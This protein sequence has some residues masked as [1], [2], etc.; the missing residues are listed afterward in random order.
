MKYLHYT[1][2]DAVTGISIE[3]EPAK[4]GPASPAIDGLVFQ[5]A[6]ESQY[7]TNLPDFFGTCPDDSFVMVDG[8]KRV[9]TQ[10]EF[11]QAWA[12]ELAARDAKRVEALW[13]AAHNKEFSA[14]SGS[15]IGM[16]ALG[17]LQSKPKCLAVQSWI[18][19]IWTEYYVRKSSCSTNTDYS[20]AGD[21]P[22]SVPELMAEVYGS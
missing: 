19:S 3:A 14:I 11:E 10:Q 6:R 21:M 17:V 22:H 1:Y 9:L 5:W 12:E 7:P 8:V 16:L 4:N 15:A 20:F 2:V 13:E 18:A